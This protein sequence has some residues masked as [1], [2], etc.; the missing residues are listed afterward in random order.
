MGDGNVNE[1]WELN[2]DNISK[3]ANNTLETKKSKSKP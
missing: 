2:R 1:S 3:A